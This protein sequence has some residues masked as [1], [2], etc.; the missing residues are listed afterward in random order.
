MTIA[1]IKLLRLKLNR[2]NAH[3]TSLNELGNYVTCW[4]LF[5]AKR[6]DFDTFLLD[7]AWKPIFTLKDAWHFG[8][9]VNPVDRA[10]VVYEDG[11]TLLIECSSLAAYEMQLTWLSSAHEAHT[12]CYHF[13][14]EEASGGSAHCG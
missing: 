4:Q 12:A 5:D 9:W 6:Y 3:F 2:R 10:F 13:L 14:G 8:L 7:Q 11:Q 1:S